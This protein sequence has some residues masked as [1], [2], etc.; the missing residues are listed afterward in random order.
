MTE[1]IG[2]NMKNANNKKKKWLTL[3]AAGVALLLIPRRSSRKADS[4]EA[5]GNAKKSGIKVTN[6]TID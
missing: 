6:D 1:N 2:K 5:V 4:S 3:T